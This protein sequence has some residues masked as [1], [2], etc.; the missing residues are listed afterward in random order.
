MSL[1]QTLVVYCTNIKH[2]WA[3]TMIELQYTVQKKSARWRRNRTADFALLSPDCCHRCSKVSDRCYNV[4]HKKGPAG[5]KRLLP[6]C[7][8]P[9]ILVLSACQISVKHMSNKCQTAVTQVSHVTAT[10]YGIPTI[11]GGR[12]SLGGNRCLRICNGSWTRSRSG[13][14]QHCNNTCAKHEW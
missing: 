5:V 14:W 13:W 7:Q 8:A 12:L 6:R 2:V 3:M 1:I 11:A 10:K 4:S 9:V